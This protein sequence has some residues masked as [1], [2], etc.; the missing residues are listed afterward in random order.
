M[1]FNFVRVPLNLAEPE[2]FKKYIKEKIKP[3]LT[4][5]QIAKKTPQLHLQFA[6]GALA[7]S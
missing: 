5:A 7:A 4:S 6:L 1:H 3:K 2:Y